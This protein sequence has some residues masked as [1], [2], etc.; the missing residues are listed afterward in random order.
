MTEETQNI[1]KTFQT[2]LK[3][4]LSLL[5]FWQEIEPANEQESIRSID[6]LIA[7]IPDTLSSEEDFEKLKEIALNT[8]EFCQKK[9]ILLEKISVELKELNGI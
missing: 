5:E 4:E 9:K 7:E 3:R 1:I 6:D 8:M 2:M